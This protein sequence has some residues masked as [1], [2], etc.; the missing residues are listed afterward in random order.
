MGVEAIIAR[1][2][3]EAAEEAERIRRQAE[4]EATALL[5]TA[6]AQAEEEQKRILRA[7]EKEAAQSAKV[8]LANARMDARRTIRGVKEEIIARCFRLAEEAL[9]EIPSSPEYPEI[10]RDLIADGIGALGAP[11]VEICPFEQ[12]RGV[13]KGIVQGMNHPDLRIEVASVCPIGCGGVILRTPDRR[14][15]V[16]N[17]FTA[18]L[19]RERGRLIHECALILFGGA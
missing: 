15:S 2:R 4:A 17:T 5:E 3:R 9:R 7:G 8:I 10:L 1:M 14:V 16:N 12:D 19:E 18:R 13:V 6:R 11:V